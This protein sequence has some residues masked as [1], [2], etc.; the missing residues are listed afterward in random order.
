MYRDISIIKII[1]F[2]FKFREACL[3]KG[4]LRFQRKRKLT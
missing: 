4:E 2:K 1:E 3:N